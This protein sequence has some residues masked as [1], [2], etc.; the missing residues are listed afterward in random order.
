MGNELN[1]L[2]VMSKST[3]LWVANLTHNQMV[4]RRFE[5][6]SIQNGNG[7][8]AMPGTIPVPNPGSF[9]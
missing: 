1:V 6:H 8:K 5:S 9:N 4:R 3:V 2:G 7:V